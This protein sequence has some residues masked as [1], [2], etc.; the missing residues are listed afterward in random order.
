MP[1]MPGAGMPGMPGAGMP[2]MPGAGMPGMQP[3]MPG[4]RQQIPSQQEA[5]NTASQGQNNAEDSPKKV[6]DAAML[7]K[8]EAN[9][10]YRRKAYEQ[11]CSK[12]YASI[13]KI[14]ENNTLK[15]SKEGKDAMIACRGNLSLCKLMLEDYEGVID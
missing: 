3:G 13:N 8:A 2:G 6:L 9:G 1:G 4:M 12:F 14:C 15:N 5:K 11:A 10:F 7:L